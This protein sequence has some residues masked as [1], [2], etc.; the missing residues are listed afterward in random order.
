MMTERRD[1]LHTLTR[2]GDSE[3]GGAYHSPSENINLENAIDKST[4]G[5]RE[6]Q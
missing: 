6:R 5:R 1:K 3:S 2:S 4:S